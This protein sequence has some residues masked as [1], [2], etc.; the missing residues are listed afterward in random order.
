VDDSVRASGL[1]GG[2]ED[3]EAEG[4]AGD[5][6]AVER[7]AA[8]HLRGA[9]AVA[10]GV[11][12]DRLHQRRAVERRSTRVGHD[13]ATGERGARHRVVA[14]LS[15]GH[16]P[17]GA[18]LG[19][20]GD[21]V[22]PLD[23]DVVVAG[24]PA[25]GD[26]EPDGEEWVLPVVVRAG[27]GVREVPRV[28]LDGGGAIHDPHEPVELVLLGVV[29]VV[30]AHEDE[31]HGQQGREGVDGADRGVEDAALIPLLGAERPVGAAYGCRHV[32]LAE[33]VGRLVI[34]ELDVGQ[35][36]EAEEHGGARPP[37][38]HRHAG[39]RDP[40]EGL[41]CAQ[42]GEPVAFAQPCREDA[43]GGR[44]ARVG[45]AHE[46]VRRDDRDVGRDRCSGQGGELRGGLDEGCIGGVCVL[47]WRTRRIGLVPR[48][49]CHGR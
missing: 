9:E 36:H 6:E 23:L 15:E 10:I 22:G 20:G 41:P 5:V 17:D 42:G 14:R 47:A 25:P 21:G 28:A 4:G 27:D 7:L 37:Y 24:D 18:R 11:R 13:G 48:V 45:R 38:R 19:L 26:R 35:V 31:R 39:G 16:R 40:H 33:A 30:P 46:R 43:R 34:H 44:R 29:D 49:D 12:G 1:G 32:E 2:V 3:D 8:R